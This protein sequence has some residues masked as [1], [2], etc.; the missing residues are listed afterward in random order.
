M[1][2]V[3]ISYSYGKVV[4]LSKFST[5]C[6]TIDGA[7]PT[8]DTLNCLEHRNPARDRVARARNEKYLRHNDVPGP[9]PVVR[10]A[11]TDAG[12]VKTPSE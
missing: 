1:D 12:T 11:V 2:C 5:A 7:S 4:F 8:R 9:G 10:Q 6:A 3:C